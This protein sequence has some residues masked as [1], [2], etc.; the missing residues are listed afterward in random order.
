VH[1]GIVGGTGPAGRALAAR[2]ADV[3]HHIALGSR[4]K[5]RA[6]EEVDKILDSW[7]ERELSIEATDNQGAAAAELVVIATPWDAAASVAGSVAPHLRGKVVVTMANALER[8][9]N[10]F[11]PLIPPRGSVAAHV[12][13]IV[14]EAKVAAAFQHVPA[15]ELGSLDHPVES[16]VLVCSDHP[17]ATKIVSGIVNGI[18]DLRALDSGE[19]SNAMA[20]EAFT[21]VMLQLNTR[22][23]TR[24]ALRIMGVTT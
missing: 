13:A 22:Y 16:D 8:V 5:Y 23:R 7:P 19:L 21:A 4:S 9:A 11:E 17:E 2:L 18:P 6:L 24:V 14:P 20:I 15:K 3:G 1:I 12:Q 10:E